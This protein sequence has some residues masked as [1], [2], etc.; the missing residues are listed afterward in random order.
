MLFVGS[1]W[2]IIHIYGTIL[3]ELSQ[4]QILPDPFI[5]AMCGNDILDNKKLCQVYRD[6]SLSTYLSV[7]V[8]QTLK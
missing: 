6:L 4:I 1:S 7:I 2:I 3:P 8:K 5:S